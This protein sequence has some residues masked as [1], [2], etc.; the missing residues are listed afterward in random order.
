M[1]FVADVET[2][3]NFWMCLFKNIDTGEVIRFQQSPNV[4]M[5]RIG[6]QDVMDNNLTIWFN[7]KTYDIPMVQ[8]AIKGAT[9]E[10]LYQASNDLIVGEMK[11]KEFR[12][13]Y[14]ITKNK[15]ND[16]DLIEVAP[17]KASLKI[18]GGRLHCKKMQSLPLSPDTIINKETA[19]L[20]YKYCCNDLEVTELLYRELLP[21]INLRIELGK[22]YGK[23]FRSSKGSQIAESAITSEVENLTGKRIAKPLPDKISFKYNVPKYIK[24]T[25]PQ[26]I[27]FLKKLQTAEFI[28]NED[29]EVELPKFIKETV[30]NLEYGSYKPS[31]GGL[32]SLE[33]CVK[34]E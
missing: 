5:N 32:H 26:L 34:Y 19:N 11:S 20:L 10:E 31:I 27:D 17:L 4:K 30:I 28:T 3:P 8:L 9:C 21:E 12:N 29:G 2:Y 13:K 16:I 14:G 23:D 22:Q 1:V 25:S 15:F 18:Y 6:L 33:S 7:G 24:F